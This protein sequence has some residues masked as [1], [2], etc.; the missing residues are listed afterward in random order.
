MGS[1]VK[2][3][4]K[5][6]SSTYLTSVTDIHLFFDYAPSVAKHSINGSHMASNPNCPIGSKISDPMI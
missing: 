5:H 6:T 1:F 4:P 2:G 3:A